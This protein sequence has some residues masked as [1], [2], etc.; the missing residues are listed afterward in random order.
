MDDFVNQMNRHWEATDA[1][2]LASL[3]LWRL[4]YIHPF[5]NGN[6]RTARAA[7]LFTLCVKAGGW[8]PG[9]PVLPELIKR[10]RVRYVE[11]LRKVDDSYKSGSLNLKPLH[12]LLS[13]LI[14][15]QLGS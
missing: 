1:V 9:D 15:E 13:E 2:V 3:V 14:D 8:L 11:A 12:S 5:E 4:N 10:E 7:C 6:G